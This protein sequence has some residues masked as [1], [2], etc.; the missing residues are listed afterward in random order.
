MYSWIIFC[1][2]KNTSGKQNVRLKVSNHTHTCAHF[3]EE[4]KWR[5]LTPTLPFQRRKLRSNTTGRGAPGSQWL[6]A[7]SMGHLPSQSKRKKS[8]LCVRSAW[9]TGLKINRQLSTSKLMTPGHAVLPHLYKTVYYNT[10]FFSK[11]SPTPL[12]PQKRRVMLA[13]TGNGALASISTP[14]LGSH[15]PLLRP[16][17]TLWAAPAPGST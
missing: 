11:Y 1:F 16:T 14:S 15:L 3:V 8:I 10:S 13:T 6:R 7:Q 5:S 4:L 12:L 2:A 9:R 17:A